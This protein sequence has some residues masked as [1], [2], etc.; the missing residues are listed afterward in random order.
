MKIIAG[1][2]VALAMIAGTGTAIALNM[3][4]QQTLAEEPCIGL[5]CWPESPATK[6]RPAQRTA[7]TARP[8]Q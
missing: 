6:H 7:V 4:Q 1:W 2:L 3:K 5:G 8:T